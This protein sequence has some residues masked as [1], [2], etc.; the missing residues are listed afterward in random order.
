MH[1]KDTVE[2]LFHRR[3]KEEEYEKMRRNESRISTI[4][5]QT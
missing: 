3:V 4:K 1:I 2:K 5:N